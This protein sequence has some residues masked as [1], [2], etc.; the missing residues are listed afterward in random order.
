MKIFSN[1]DTK[2]KEKLVRRKKTTFKEEDII[3]IIRSKYYF[4][5]QVLCPFI[6]FLLL[7]IG[8]FIFLQKYNISWYIAIAL[9]LVW[10]LVVW[11]KVVHKLL[12]Y[13]YDFT[14]IVPRGIITYKQKGILFSYLKEIPA[15][16]VRSIQVSRNAFLGNVFWYGSVDLLTDFTDNMHIGEEDE[17]P[18]VIWMTYVDMPYKVKNKITDLCF[19]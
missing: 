7:A 3:V 16:R 2:F 18:S 10:I 4:F 5:F 8:V 19:K 13:L 12:K 17:A 14:V 15:N 1:F 11:F 9:I 6:V